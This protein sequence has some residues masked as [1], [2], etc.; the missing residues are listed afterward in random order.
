MVRNGPI[1]AVI[2]AFVV[3]TML[4]ISAAAEEAA[5][6]DGVLGSEEVG[7]GNERVEAGEPDPESLVAPEAV[8]EEPD[9][10]LVEL[11]LLA[12]LA[13]DA[14]GFGFRVHASEKLRY[15][16]QRLSGGFDERQRCDALCA[17]LA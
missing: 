11:T 13:P 8:T 17:N 4:P 1:T 2:F 14:H 15:P 10:V 3:L 12:G 16:L 5:V 7:G 6:F 9:G